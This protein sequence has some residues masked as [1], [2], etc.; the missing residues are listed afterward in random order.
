MRSLYRWR[1]MAVWFPVTVFA[2]STA[3]ATSAVG[4]ETRKRL[5]V[6]PANRDDPSSPDYRVPAKQRTGGAARDKLLAAVKEQLDAFTPKPP[7]TKK[8]DEDFYVVGTIDLQNHH[9]I[10]DFVIEE[11]VQQT[12]NFIADFVLGKEFGEIREWRVFA[13]AKTLKVAE[14]LRTKAKSESI[15]DQL[16]A[17]KLTTSGKKSPDDCFV[18]GTADLDLATL[19]ANIRFEILS[20]IKNAADFIIDFTFNLPKNHKGEWHV[21]YRA[22]TEAKASEFRQAMRD[23]Y[24][25][26]VAQRNQIAAIYKAKTTARC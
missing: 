12:A 7:R 13:R 18:I 17:F 3:L 25:S 10:V 5:P 4:Q 9:A 11:G 22:R 19:H 21:F 20:G 14:V 2:I 6:T 23:S 26:L 24:D 16:T 15:E 8:A 1:C